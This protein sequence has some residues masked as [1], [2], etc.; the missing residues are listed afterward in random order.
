MRFDNIALLYKKNTL[1]K[2]EAL[3]RSLKLAI[4][5]TVMTLSRST[6]AIFAHLGHSGFDPNRRSFMASAA[7]GLL[8]VSCAGWMAP[9]RL[10][11][12]RH[13]C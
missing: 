10:A 8:G 2:N 1:V 5:R 4:G 7:K 11:V 9:P 6:I 3:N 13:G 12:A